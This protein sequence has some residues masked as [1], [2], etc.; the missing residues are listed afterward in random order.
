M[1]YINY[2]IKSLKE[3]LIDYFQ[4]AINHFDADL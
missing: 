2:D 1:N 4:S 3:D